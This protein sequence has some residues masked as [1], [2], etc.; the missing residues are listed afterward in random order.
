[1]AMMPNPVGVVNHDPDWAASFRLEAAVVLAAELA[2]VAIVVLQVLRLPAA[3]GWLRADGLAAV[4]AAWTAGSA[5][6]LFGRYRAYRRSAP[7][8]LRIEPDGVVGIFGQ[9]L[10]GRPN[11]EVVRL[12]FAAISEIREAHA[13]LGNRAGVGYAP[14]RVRVLGDRPDVVPLRD[15]DGGSRTRPT[16]WREVPRLYLSGTTLL[17]VRE[18]YQRWRATS[19]DAGRP[20][21]DGRRG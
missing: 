5:A 17:A 9:H 13:G 4:L 10:G 18:E 1:M 16:P 12:P 21:H 2:V 6:L 15:R 8:W 20:P 3:G 7:D 19:R 11:G 14:P